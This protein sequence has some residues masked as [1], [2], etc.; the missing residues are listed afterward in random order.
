MKLIPNSAIELA[1]EGRDIELRNAELWRLEGELPEG[2]ITLREYAA[3][4]AYPLAIAGHS[5]AHHISH[6]RG[7]GSAPETP[8]TFLD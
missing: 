1:A 5:I 8:P 7:G 4:A 3:R 2:F 6:L